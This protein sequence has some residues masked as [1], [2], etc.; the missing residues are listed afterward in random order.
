[1][2]KEENGGSQLNIVNIDGTGTVEEVWQA[3]EEAMNSYVKNDVLT[4]NMKALREE[5]DDVVAAVSNAQVD[6]IDGIEAVVSYDRDSE[7]GESTIRETRKWKHG[8]AGWRC[9]DVKQT[10]N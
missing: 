9:V 3:T 2:Q 4:A 8:P 1:M 6:M 10:T 7:D 5:G